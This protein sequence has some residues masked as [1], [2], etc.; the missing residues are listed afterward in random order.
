MQ[1]QRQFGLDYTEGVR[2]LGFE[3]T[4]DW[5]LLVDVGGHDAAGRPIPALTHYMIRV[6]T[7]V[8]G[9]LVTSLWRNGLVVCSPNTRALGFRAAH[10]GTVPLPLEAFDRVD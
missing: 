2:E 10:H 7:T 5:G 1:Q 8:E 9:L 4:N 3:R 6:T